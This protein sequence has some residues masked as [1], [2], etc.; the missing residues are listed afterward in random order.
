MAGLAVLLAATGCKKD[1]QVSKHITKVHTTAKITMG[2]TTISEVN[3]HEEWNWNGDKLSTLKYY[4]DS[5]L[6]HTATY[7]YSGDKLTKIE[8]I[9]TDGESWYTLEIKYDTKDRISTTKQTSNFGTVVL[10]EYEY[11]S[12]DKVSGVKS[13]RINANGETEKVSTY[14]ITWTGDNITAMTNADGETTTFAFDSHPNPYYGIVESDRE[15]IWMSKNNL[16]SLDDQTINYTYDNDGWPTQMTSE[17]V[18]GTST[19]HSS[20]V[21]EYDR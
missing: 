14:T 1:E 9:Y 2:E 16:T 11:G 18:A 19:L 8:D 10:S 6:R 12:S 20:R 21:F 17:T 15:Y 7:T 13:T 3:T 4:T 5:T